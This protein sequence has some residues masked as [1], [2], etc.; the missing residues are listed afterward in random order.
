MLLS[1]NLSSAQGGTIDCPSALHHGRLRATCECDTLERAA[2]RFAEIF[3]NKHLVAPDNYLPEFLV[4]VM[5]WSTS[6]GVFWVSFCWK[7]SHT[8]DRPNDFCA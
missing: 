5:P 4:R 8:G 3:L 6:P 2:L 7:K 1:P